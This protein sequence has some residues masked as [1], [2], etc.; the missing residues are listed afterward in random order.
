MKKILLS[1]L[2]PLVI[3][4]SNTSSSNV[5]TYVQN[6][7]SGDNVSVN[8][9]IKNNI[10]GQETTTK[11]DKPGS[12]KVEAKNDSIKITTDSEITPTVTTSLKVDKEESSVGKQPIKDQKELLNEVNKKIEDLSNRIFS[13]VDQ[14]FSRFRIFRFNPINLST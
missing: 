3:S 7:V 14:F 8:T 1:F 10:N 13:L 9:E 11:V 2:L 12:I 4:T 6:E 5:S